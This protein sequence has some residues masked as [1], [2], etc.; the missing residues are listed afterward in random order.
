MRFD[1]YRVLL[2][3]QLTSQSTDSQ[4]CHGQSLIHSHKFFPW[5]ISLLRIQHHEMKNGQSEVVQNQGAGGVAENW[6]RVH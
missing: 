1:Y 4:S 2:H 5:L 3:F 6:Q